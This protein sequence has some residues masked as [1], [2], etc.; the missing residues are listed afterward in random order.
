M[1]FVRWRGDSAQRLATVWEVGHAR[2][3]LLANL[4]EVYAASV[5]LREE[6][7]TRFPALTVDWAAV[8]RALAAGRSGPRA[9]SPRP[10]VGG[11]G[12][13]SPHLGAHHRPDA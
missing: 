12:P 10:H 5:S 2:Q 4:H 1:A 11:D 8:D 3:I 6:V 13:Q 9:R 7:A